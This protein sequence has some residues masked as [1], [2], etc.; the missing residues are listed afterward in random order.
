MLMDAHSKKLTTA[1]LA[2]PS[3]LD[4]EIVAEGIESKDQMNCLLAHGCNIG[5]GYFFSAP[6]RS[7][8]LHKVIER[9]ELR[10]TA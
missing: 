3:A 7:E 9:I 6:V 2:M 10:L 5:Q 8:E 1:I 4:L